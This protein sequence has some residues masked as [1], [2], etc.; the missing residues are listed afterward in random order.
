MQKR[1]YR[2]EQIFKSIQKTNL[3]TKIHKPKMRRQ[4]NQYCTATKSE[5]TAKNQPRTISP[6][7]ML[8]RVLPDD[9]PD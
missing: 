4:F 2:T 5:K 9:C 6:G 3:T 7:V 8:N 1:E